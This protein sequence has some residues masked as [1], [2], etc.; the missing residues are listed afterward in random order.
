MML[1]KRE[2]RAKLMGRCGTRVRFRYPGNNTRTGRLIDRVVVFSS[3]LTDASYW[4]VIDLIEFPDHKHRKWIRISYYRQVG[5]K[6][7]WA[8]Q[9][10]ITEPLH[11]WKR[12]FGQGA[13][14]K[15]WFRDVLAS[16][17]VKQG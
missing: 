10:S 1:T 8:G 4:D 12:I 3:R 17:V 16:A 9:T 6:L 15:N 5:D 13:R 11:V 14:K 7:R 2:V